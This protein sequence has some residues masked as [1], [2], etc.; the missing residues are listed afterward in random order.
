MAAL[1][2]LGIVEQFEL[3]KMEH[4]S[5]EYLHTL[6]EAMRLAFAD[7]A[8]VN[9]DPQVR[10]VPL[11]TLLN[12]E[13]LTSRGKLIDTSRATA[14]AHGAP[15][16]SSDTVYFNAVDAYGNA[17][18][19]INSNYMGFGSGIVPEGCG[20]SLQNRG[21][22]F[23]L[24]PA[25]PNCVAPNKR[26]YHTIIPGMVTVGSEFEMCF[27]VMGGFMQP[28]GHLQVLCNMLD[29]GMEPQEA[30]DKP[31]FCIVPDFSKPNVFPQIGIEEGV[32]PQHIDYLKRLGHNVKEVSGYDRALFGRGQIIRKISN[33]ES[34]DVLWAGS[35]PR[36][37]GCALG[38]V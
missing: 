31:R 9:T 3:S 37:D 23:S 26:P 17:C 21:H 25:H 13:Y 22:N 14:I 19:M 28:Q 15:H 18:S 1:M 12:P 34:G 30:L 20:F 2:A 11:A 35:D 32:A 6:I 27:G 5:G 24:D 36:A 8:A 7:T 33:P 4:N 16:T 38:Y 29:F 10:D